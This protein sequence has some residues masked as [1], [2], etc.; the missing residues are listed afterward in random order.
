M[1]WGTVVRFFWF[2]DNCSS[3]S[4]AKVVDS[5]DFWSEAKWLILLYKLNILT[6]QHFDLLIKGI[7]AGCVQ[8][9]L[10]TFGSLF[11]WR[12]HFFN[13]FGPGSHFITYV[14]SESNRY[15]Y[16]S[17]DPRSSHWTI[18]IP[19]RIPTH[20]ENF[21]LQKNPDWHAWKPSRIPEQCK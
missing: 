9:F 20:F 14:L 18:K 12:N 11:S 6:C 15:D 8:F 10:M 4:R 17:Q 3:L 7:D 13:Y 21:T 19:T 5:K 16:Q 1:H 2:F